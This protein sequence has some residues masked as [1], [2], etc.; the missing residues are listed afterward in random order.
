MM[1]ALEL[2]HGEGRSPKAIASS[3]GWPVELVEKVFGLAG[4]ANDKGGGG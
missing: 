4:E 1:K 2:Y 3:L